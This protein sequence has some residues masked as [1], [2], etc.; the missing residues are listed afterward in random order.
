MSPF[1]LALDHDAGHPDETF[2]ASAAR[3]GTNRDGEVAHS[4]ILGAGGSAARRVTIGAASLT[5][6]RTPSCDLV[7]EGGAVS[8]EHLRL[9]VEGGH[10]VARD[11]GSTNGTLLDGA[12]L[13]APAVLQHGATLSVGSHLLTYERRTMREVAEAA[14][15]DRDLR[16]ASAYVQ[17][18]LPEPLRDGP[19]RRDWMFLPCAQLGGC[20]F[21]AEFLDPGRFAVFMI[22]VMDHGT[23]AA[24]QSVALMNLLAR[25]LMPGVDFGDPAAVLAGLN[26]SAAGGRRD[27][28]AAVWYGVL[29]VAGGSSPTPRRGTSPRS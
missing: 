29:D 21:G 7:L 22:H 1:P 18:L 10:L 15:L 25:R 8:R 6:G 2:V 16:D 19:V 12:R 11:L 20:G 4:L 27:A 9:E 17:S 13:L 5:I 28:R 3:P 26:G 14:A 24:M 23:T